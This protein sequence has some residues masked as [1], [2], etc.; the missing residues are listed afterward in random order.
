MA[1]IPLIEVSEIIDSFDLTEVAAVINSQISVDDDEMQ[2]TTPQIDHFKPVYVAY[3]R[4]INNPNVDPDDI[5]EAKERFYNIC[6]IILNLIEKKFEFSI[7]DEWLNGHMSSIPAITLAFYSFFVIDFYYNMV[8]VVQNYIVSHMSDL[9]KTFAECRSKKDAATIANRKHLSLEMTIIA[10]NIFD[11]V[12]WILNYL[13]IDAYFD[14]MDP[15]YKALMAIKALYDNGVSDGDFVKAIHGIYKGSIS[16]RAQLG[17]DILARIKDG[18][19]DDPY[20]KES[21][22]LANMDD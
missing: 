15:G 17:T 8:E 12:D 4:I 5:E 10:A 14:C 22:E 9:V 18:K 3:K 6:T 2:Y 16:L 19:I 7:D 21:S 11:V 1:D 20:P 13:D